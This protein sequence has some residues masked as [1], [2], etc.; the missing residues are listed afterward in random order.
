MISA[1][2]CIEINNIIYCNVVTYLYFV[3]LSM[4]FVCLFIKQLLIHFVCSFQS[5]SFIWVPEITWP[6]RYGIHNVCEVE[7]VDAIKLD[8]VEIVFWNF[9]SCGRNVLHILVFKKNRKFNKPDD[10]IGE[11]PCWPAKWAR[12]FSLEFFNCLPLS[13][14]S[15]KKSLFEMTLGGKSTEPRGV[16]RTLTTFINVA[17]FVD[18]IWTKLES[19][20]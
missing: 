4:F 16:G 19:C 13:A 1:P 5:F 10:V 3:S 8:V 18:W 17:T 14:F 11:R 20:S 7:H 6:P 2:C 9:L 12:L 15:I